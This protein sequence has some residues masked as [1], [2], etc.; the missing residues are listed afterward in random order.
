VG[1]EVICNFSYRVFHHAYPTVDPSSPLFLAGLMA[2]IG[3]AIAASL[4]MLAK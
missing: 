2:L 4:A 3:S 1:A